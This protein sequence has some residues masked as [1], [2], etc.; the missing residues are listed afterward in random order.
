MDGIA[1]HRRWSKDPHTN[2]V[3]NADQDC[4]MDSIYPTNVFDLYSLLFMDL[5]VKK[6]LVLFKVSNRNPS[7]C[8]E[9]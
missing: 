4:Q 6:L 5:N 1:E 8:T 7:E 3:F 2:P 9:E